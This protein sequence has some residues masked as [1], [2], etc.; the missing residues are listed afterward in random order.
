MLFEQSKNLPVV[1]LEFARWADATEAGPREDPAPVVVEAMYDGQ[2]E[3]AE[4]EL[5]MQLDQARREARAEAMAECEERMRADLAIE[6]SAIAHALTSFAQARQRY[7]SDVEHE[8]VKLALSISERILQREVA[9]DAT[10]LAGVVHVALDKLGD[11]DGAILRVPMN[12]VEMWQRSSKMAGIEIRGDMKLKNGDLVL[13]A[14]GGVAE[15][16]VKAQLEE[17]ERG[18]FDLLAKRPA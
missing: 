6:R 12:E 10:L 3:E 16:G 8:V 5:A 7:F 13:E 2:A 11:R 4:R 9:M 18:F 1:P 17:V 14:A 15:L